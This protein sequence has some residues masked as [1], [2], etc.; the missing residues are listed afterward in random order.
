MGSPVHVRLAPAGPGPRSTAHALLLDLA[1]TL[2]DDPVLD[3][4]EAGRP[5]I[6][7]LAVSITYGHHRLAVAASTGGPL[8]IDLEEFRPRDV[9]ALASRW[10]DPRELDWLDR[11]SDQLPAFLRLWTAKEAVGKALGHGLENGGLRRRMPCGAAGPVPGVAGLTVMHQ[12]LPDAVLAVACSTGS[13]LC[14]TET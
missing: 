12:E 6:P 14:V 3:H 1:G 9:G 4:D 8:G 13:I 5:H 2:V 11:Q 10:F 7:G